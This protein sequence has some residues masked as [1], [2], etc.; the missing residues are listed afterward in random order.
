M[1]NKSGIPVLQTSH[2]NKG[3]WE[4][5]V[6]TAAAMTV[7]PSNEMQKAFKR[8]VHHGST[9]NNC[10]FVVNNKVSDSITTH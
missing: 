10:T 4:N 7:T 9:F 5:Q 1:E 3:I 6:A 8:L 2:V